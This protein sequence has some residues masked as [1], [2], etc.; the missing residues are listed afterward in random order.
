MTH[1]D[2]LLVNLA[3][4]GHL[5]LG[6]LF[7]DLLIQ[8]LDWNGFQVMVREPKEADL[9]RFVLLLILYLSVTECLGWQIPCVRVAVSRIEGSSCH[10]D[11]L[12]YAKSV[13]VFALNS[14]SIL[15]HQ[16]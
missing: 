15:A 7:A 8:V 5:I 6:Q 14:E 4:K 11:G 2:C 10:A 1:T 13:V 12:P 9:L 3:I 16:P